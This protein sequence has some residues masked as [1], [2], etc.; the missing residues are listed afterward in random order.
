MPAGKAKEL[1]RK[2][3]EEIWN[4]KRIDAADELISPAYVHHD[5]QSLQE[6]QGVDGYKE[7]V[8]YYL[9]AFPDAHFTI[10]EE[11]E[12]ANTVVTRWSVTGTHNGDLKGIAKTGKRF[13]VTG[14]SIAKMEN[15]K[16]VE[17]WNIWDALGMMQQLG[18]VPLEAK[19]RAA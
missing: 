13:S 5:P 7:F 4:N 9:N 11:I 17:S 12:H 19:G 10:H 14:I 3:F 1:S 15:G 18:V 16:F 8:R 2:I 6:P